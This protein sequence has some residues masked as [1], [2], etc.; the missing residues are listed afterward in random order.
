MKLQLPNDVLTPQD[1]KGVIAEVREYARW[2]SHAAVKQRVAGKAVAGAQPP[3]LS[4]AASSL[5]EAAAGGKPLTQPALEQLIASLED[6]ESKAPSVSIT[7][8]GPP[9][10]GLKKSLA[11]WC[12]QNIGPNVLVNF[13]FN[14]TLLGGLVIRYGSRIFD[15]SFRR[16]ILANRQ[17]FPEV[18]RRV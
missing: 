7:L 15:W 13:S 5:I 2:A 9:S 1:L 12:R 6:F 16:Q 4:P 17:K 3:A 18:L 10:N 11:T 8:A 14:S